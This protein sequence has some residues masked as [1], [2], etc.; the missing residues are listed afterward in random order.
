MDIQGKKALVTGGAKRLGNALTLMLAGAGAEVAVHYNRSETD[1]YDLCDMICNDGGTAFPVAKDLSR[2]GAA[3]DLFG[4]LDAMDFFPEI[5]IN[6]ASIFHLERLLDSSEE[7]FHRNLDINALVP[8]MLSREMAKRVDS[9][10]VINMLDSRITDYDNLHVPYHL[11]KLSLFS[12]TRMLSEELSPD[13]RFNAVAPGV[14]LPPVGADPSEEES[15]TERMK[16]SNTLKRIGTAQQVCDAAEF[17]I[18][19]DF[20]TGQIIFVDG[21]RHLKGSFYGL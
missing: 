16:N 8:L 7:T 9:G 17:L 4:D 13:F 15:W 14:I 12:L 1:A 11:S 3:E 6:S 5:L 20:V 2:K 19:N 10:V 18:R 21:G